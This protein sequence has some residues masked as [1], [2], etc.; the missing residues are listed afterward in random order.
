MANRPIPTF[1]EPPDGGWGWMVV[2]AS[3]SCSV[4]VDGIIFSSGIFLME[5]SI[6]FDESKGRTAWIGSLLAGFYLL[7]GPV[8]SA[9]AN[10]FGCRPVTI[11]GS[12][13]SSIAFILCFFAKTLLHICLCFGIVGGI[14]FGFIYLPAIVT[15]GYYFETKRAFA[16]GIAVCGSGVGAFIMPPIV[17]YLNETYGW[18][19]CLLLLSSIIMHCCVFGSLFRP[20]VPNEDNSSE[21]KEDIPNFDKFSKRQSSKS[22]FKLRAPYL[23]NIRLKRSSDGRATSL[24]FTPDNRDLSRRRHSSAFPPRRED[25]MRPFDRQDVLFSASVMRLREYRSQS[26]LEQFHK[27]IT[28]IPEAC[29]ATSSTVMTDTF[30]QLLDTSLLKSPTFL[31]LAISGFLTL[32]GFFIPFV[33]IVDRAVLI[34]ISPQDA[35]FLLSVIGITNTVAR[36]FCGWISDKPQVSSLIINNCALTIGGLATALSPFLNT[37]THLV[38]YG[39][40]FG[41]SIACFAA[42][43]SVITVELLGLEKLTNAFGLI[44][45]FQGV[46]TMVGSPIAGWFFDVTGSYDTSFYIAGSVIAVS[47]LMCFFLPCIARWEKARNNC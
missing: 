26:D 30:R 1:V 2:F 8:V 18:R 36:V 12:I 11:A 40:I 21:S 31:V 28:R 14:G 13:L 15:V 27:S 9:L 46:A 3:F 5:F 25:F 35:T 37:Y 16:T 6:T 43:R 23:L 41:F 44:L 47:G 39:A 38:I 19:G 17:N 20:L 33:Y 42:L 24:S 34:G 45:L 4:I 32:A 22:S 29:D 7:A 10:T